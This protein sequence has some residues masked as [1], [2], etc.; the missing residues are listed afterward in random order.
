[1]TASRAIGEYVAWGDVHEWARYLE[2]GYGGRFK[3][4]MT[5]ACP[6]GEQYLKQYWEVLWCDNALQERPLGQRILGSFPSR[7]H[8]SLAACFLSL[9]W[10]ADNVLAATNVWAEPT[11]AAKPRRGERP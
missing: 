10:Q 5:V 3:F 7:S 1:M 2:A 8:K 4:V 6:K 9:L 11:V